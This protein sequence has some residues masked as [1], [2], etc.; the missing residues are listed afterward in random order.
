MI[1]KAVLPHSFWVIYLLPF[2]KEGT[3][4]ARFPCSLQKIE[5][6][7]NPS[8]VTSLFRWC[9]VKNNK[10]TLLHKET[11]ECSFPLMYT[12]FE[13]CVSSSTMSSSQNALVCVWRHLL[14]AGELLILHMTRAIDSSGGG[15]SEQ[16]DR[17]SFPDQDFL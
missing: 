6:G 11:P 16:G 1:S 10:N 12:L 3:R 7:G 9:V 8:P 17:L 4:V 5:I 15:Q 2:L 14:A 13:D